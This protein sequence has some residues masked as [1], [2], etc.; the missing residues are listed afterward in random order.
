MRVCCLGTAVG[1]KVRGCRFGR[2]GCAVRVVVDDAH[3]ASVGIDGSGEGHCWLLVGLI[4][5]TNERRKKTFI[6]HSL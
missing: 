2:T 6:T 1:K 5:V 3:V 4:G